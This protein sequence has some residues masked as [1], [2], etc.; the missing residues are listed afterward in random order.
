MKISKEKLIPV[1]ESIMDGVAQ[2]GHTPEMLNINYI[3]NRLITYNGPMMLSSHFNLG[4]TSFSVS[5]VKLYNTIKTMPDTFE[6]NV[7]EETIEFHAKGKKSKTN[8]GITLTGGENIIFS[9]VKVMDEYLGNVKFDKLPKDFLKGLELCRFS[10]AKNSN[11]G[12]LSCLSIDRDCITSSDNTRISCYKMESSMDSFLL[13]AGQCLPLLKLNPTYYHAH[14][15]DNTIFFKN[16][17]KDLICVRAIHGEYPDYKGIVFDTPFDEK[18]ALLLPDEIVEMVRDVGMVNNDVASVEQYVTLTI[19][20]SAVT[21]ATTHVSGWGERTVELEYSFDIDFS[22]VMSCPALLE[23]MKHT[24][25][26]QVA[27]DG[28]RIIFGA[29]NYRHILPLL[30]ASDKEEKE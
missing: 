19:Q 2:T 18:G 5:G 13:P 8:F 16:G 1:L 10:A 29:E 26:V 4:S 28:T 24:A 11:L 3:N 22:V 21:V 20:D 17:K 14:E 15:Q 23:I 9:A 27:E 6:M 25:Q 12:T 30:Q 7:L